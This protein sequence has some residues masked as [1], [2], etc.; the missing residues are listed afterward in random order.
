MLV[1]AFNRKTWE[2]YFQRPAIYP[3]I[4]FGI[5]ETRGFPTMTK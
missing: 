2:G 1:N 5:A 3:K 4:S